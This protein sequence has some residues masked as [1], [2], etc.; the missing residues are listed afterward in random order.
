MRFFE[1]QSFSTAETG[2]RAFVAK[3]FTPWYV[4]YRDCKHLIPYQTDKKIANN[5]RAKIALKT[6][7][8][9]LES[10]SSLKFIEQTDQKRY[11][12]FT[13]GYGCHSFIGQQKKSGP[14]SIT[15]GNGCFYFDTIIHEVEL[16][17]VT[18]K[19][20]KHTTLLDNACPWI[21]A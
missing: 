2:E 16:V 5:I 12:Y 14:Q 4:T 8:K 1:H 6:A 15:L 20:L 9:K 10:N 3:H 13:H 21:P 17:D 11:L 7:F 19:A 18:N